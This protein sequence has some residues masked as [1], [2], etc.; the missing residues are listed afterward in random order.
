[1]LYV[2]LAAVFLELRWFAQEMLR[3]YFPGIRNPERVEQILSR[4]LDPAALF[5]RNR[6]DGARDPSPRADISEEEVHDYFHK[7]T[8]QAA[9]TARRGN[10]VRAAILRTQAARVAP[11]D[12][13]EE[14]CQAAEADMQQLTEWLQQ[15]LDFP[16]SEGPEWKKDLLALLNKADQGKRPVEADLLFDLQNIHLDFTQ[17]LYSLNLLGWLSRLGDRELRRPLPNQR[18]VRIIRHLRSAIA[19]LTTA[20]LSEFDRRHLSNLLHG[21]VTRSEDQLRRRLRPIF[22]TA[23]TDVGL[24]PTNP[25]ERAAFQTVIEEILDR[26]VENGFL[27]FSDLRD[28]L[29]RNQ[30]K[31]PDLATAEE[32]FRH[33]DALLRLDRR[34]ASVLDGVYRS[35]DLYMRWMEWLAA[36]FFGTMRGRAFTLWALIPFVGGLLLVEGVNQLLHWFGVPSIPRERVVTVPPG[37]PPPPLGPDG[38]PLTEPWRVPFVLI[39]LGVSLFILGL[40]HLPGLRAFWLSLFERIGTGFHWLFV[41][42]PVRFA[43]SP[44]LLALARSWPAQTFYWVILRPGVVCL[45][46][47]LLWPWLFT[48]WV[49][50]PLVFFAL[51]ALMNW[52]YGREFTDALNQVLMAIVEMLRAGLI[53]G[54]LRALIQ[55]VRRIVDLFEYVF[56]LMDEWLRFRGGENWFILTMRG[57]VGAVWSVISYVLHFYVVVLIEPGF[58]PIKMPLSIL[59][60]K[61]VYP[62]FLPGVGPL[63]WMQPDPDASFL[64]KAF[65]WSTI[66]LL[67]DALTFL[68]WEL[69]ENWRLF[70]ANRPATIE[71]VMVG[72]HGETMRQLLELRFHSGTVP[73]LYARLRAAERLAAETGNW[74]PVRSYRR[75]LEQ[76]GRSVERFFDR[77]LV[78]LLRQSPNWKEAPLSVNE[79]HLTVN[80]IY[81]TLAHEHYPG[82]PLVLVLRE[83]EGWLTACVLEHGWAQNL[84]QDQLLPLRNALLMVYKLAAVDL[85][86]EQIRAALPRDAATFDITRKELLVWK[87]RHQPPASAYRWREKSEELHPHVPGRPDLPV[88]DAPVIPARKLIYARVPLSWRDSVTCWS[89]NTP[90]ADLPALLPKGAGPVVSGVTRVLP[91]MAES[92]PER[93]GADDAPAPHPFPK[94]P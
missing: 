42:L 22:D 8:R 33:G 20:R 19:R 65:I 67:P 25:P 62:L 64:V 48:S 1:M 84:G 82:R 2:E 72:S 34:L 23:L 66:W 58:N 90:I 18:L 10:I 94:L 35:S 59:F 32:F 54:A 30:L 3:T 55:G 16:A 52:R 70:A 44:R 37:Y 27:T 12:L 43:R 61:I 83:V 56:F 81:V 77:N 26:I 45:L 11:S 50:G 89:H 60:A 36:L 88:H 93:N 38:S 71:P 75:S 73:R 14:T 87:D 47:G 31:M 68:C 91:T 53:Q 51:S 86:W 41:E 28:T 5:D 74:Q 13:V 21:A 6:L 29:S 39:W 57:I 49:R 40:V 7:L 9:S 17:E 46:I 78:T 92:D 15:A 69:K 85:V 79:V 63:A 4:G 76:V 80:A 24:T